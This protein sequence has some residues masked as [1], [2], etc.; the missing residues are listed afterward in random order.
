MFFGSLWTIEI[1]E[2]SGRNVG[3]GQRIGSRSLTAL[4]FPPRHFSRIPSPP[5][6]DGPSSYPTDNTRFSH[7]SSW[8][9]DRAPAPTGT[10]PVVAAALGFTIRGMVFVAKGRPQ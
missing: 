9:A 6:F 7:L 3:T 1:Q 10:R 5:N 8:V 2:S 4:P